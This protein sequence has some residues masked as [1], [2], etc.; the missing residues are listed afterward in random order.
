MLAQAKDFGVLEPDIVFSCEMGI[1][2][3]L[4]SWFCL[5]HRGT[6]LVNGWQY[7][8]EDLERTGVLPT[9]P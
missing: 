5:S 1:R 2:T 3:L 8:Q 4:S 7:E 6:P 9:I